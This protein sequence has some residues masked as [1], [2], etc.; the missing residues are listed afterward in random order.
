MSLASLRA[1]A[2]GRKLPE[3]LLKA[4]LTHVLL[5]LDFLHAEAG[6]IHTGGRSMGYLCAVQSSELLTLND[7]RHPG[8]EYSIGN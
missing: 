4:T 5:A 8:E 6:V 7:C 1:K 2:R 3:D